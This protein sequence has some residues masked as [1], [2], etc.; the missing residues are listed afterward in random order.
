[1]QVPVSGLFHWIGTDGGQRE[2]SNPAED[3]RAEVRSVMGHHAA[4]HTSLL[5]YSKLIRNGQVKLQRLENIFGNW[6]DLEEQARPNEV[7]V[8]ISPNNEVLIRSYPNGSTS[9]SR[10]DLVSKS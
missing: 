5:T 2:W 4:T 7:L 9:R 3:S 8:K 1:M 10:R 6:I